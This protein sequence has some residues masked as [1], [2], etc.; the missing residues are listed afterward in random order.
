MISPSVL[1]LGAGPRCWRG[2]FEFG[3]YRRD[4]AV[5]PCTGIRR[6]LAGAASMAPHQVAPS[7]S[8]GWNDLTSRSQ[9]EAR[10]SDR[11]RAV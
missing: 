9:D 10:V 8:G 2:G 4:V 3:Q 11:P 5:L 7:W 6:A 1:A